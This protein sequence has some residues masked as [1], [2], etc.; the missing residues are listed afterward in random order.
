MHP[1]PCLN[2]EAHTGRDNKF[3][4]PSRQRT[5]RPSVQALVH[6]R[7]TLLRVRVHVRVS[8]CAR[9]N[10]GEEGRGRGE[11]RG[12]KGGAWKGSVKRKGDGCT[13]W[14][15]VMDVQGVAWRAVNPPRTLR[16][17]LRM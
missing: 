14:C 1:K 6:D 9:V 3:V 4:H 16:D 10:D 7:L 8:V 5:A 12:R 13:G 2:P 17:T 11:D 15:A